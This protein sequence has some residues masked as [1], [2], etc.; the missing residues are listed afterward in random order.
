MAKPTCS[1]TVLKVLL[2]IYDV[3]F[4]TIGTLVLAIGI[5]AEVVKSEYKAVSD[6]MNSPTLFLIIIGAVMWIFG[7]LGCVGTLRENIT[8]LKIY[9]GVILAIIIL[10]VMAGV[11]ALVFKT[12]VRDFTAGEI[13][14]AMEYYDTDLDLQN[15]ID[16]M[17]LNL[18]CCGGS[19]FNDW[20]RNR[21]FK[22][23]SPSRA[24]CGVPYSCCVSSAEEGEVINSQCGYDTRRKERLE[25]EGIIFIRG[26]ADAFIIWCQDN[27][28]IMAGIILGIILPQCLGVFLAYQFI[29]EIKHQSWIV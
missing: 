5:Y 8:M 29:Q 17:Q 18:R 9:G 24:A 20:N 22:C 15:G 1:H 3:F 7:F 10:E 14:R 12:Y 11:T 28:D 4:W 26:C 13:A 27:L 25:L 2:C 19:D 23:T 21:Y 6:L 16:A